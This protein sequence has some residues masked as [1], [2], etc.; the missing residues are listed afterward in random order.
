MSAR[1]SDPED[2]S[3]L[4]EATKVVWEKADPLGP[5]SHLPEEEKLHAIVHYINT[6]RISPNP[7]DVETAADMLPQLAQFPSIHSRRCALR[8]AEHFPQA[9]LAKQYWK[10]FS[11]V[12]FDQTASELYLLL[13]SRSNNNA[14][15][16]LETIFG[17]K[18][19]T[20]SS[21]PA[22]CYL[23]ALLCCLRP[24]NIDVARILYQQFSNNSENS[25]DVGLHTLLLDVFRRALRYPHIIKTHQPDKI[26]SIVREIKFPTLLSQRQVDSKKRLILLDRI[27]EIME[28]RFNQRLDDETKERVRGDMKFALRWREIIRNENSSDEKPPEVELPEDVPSTSPNSG[29][30]SSTQS[31]IRE[32][33]R[34]AI[35]ATALRRRAAVDDKFI[36][37]L[38]SQRRLRQPAT[39]LRA[40]NRS[41]STFSRRLHP[42]TPNETRR[43]FNYTKRKKRFRR[44]VINPEIVAEPKNTEYVSSSREDISLDT[45]WRSPLYT[46]KERVVTRTGFMDEK[47]AENI[48]KFKRLDEE[49]EKFGSE[50]GSWNSA[51]PQDPHTT[52]DVEESSFTDNSVQDEF[53]TSIFW[54]TDAEE[55]DT[56]STASLPTRKSKKELPPTTSATWDPFTAMYFL[57]QARSEMEDKENRMPTPIPPKA[58]LIRLPETADKNNTKESGENVVN[59]RVA[60]PPVIKRK[61]IVIRLLDE[62]AQPSNVES[63]PD[64]SIVKRPTSPASPTPSSS[65][66]SVDETT[67][68]APRSSENGTLRSISTQSSSQRP[69]V[70]PTAIE[71]RISSMRERFRSAD[72]ETENG[73]SEGRPCD[74][75]SM[76]AEDRI[77]L[78]RGRMDRVISSKSDNF[79]GNS[80]A[81]KGEASKNVQQRQARNVAIPIGV[82][83]S[84]PKSLQKANEWTRFKQKG[85]E[86]IHKAETRS[87]VGA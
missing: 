57:S 42:N 63:E 48:K 40:N 54:N 28:W 84:G 15:E 43:P 78:M 76:S 8:L 29:T 62:P 79:A 46:G 85:W 23:H 41:F 60:E 38:A 51:S 26:Y 35:N 58:V 12:P 32:T 6:L 4:I 67:P 25:R 36:S 44:P 64:T 56:D 24:P 80:V 10:H 55:V 17:I 59:Y 71:E 11:D 47:N 31:E 2:L 50:N 1:E 75:L 49:D 83:E 53:T 18:E 66:E 68:N 74:V 39:P 14:E 69:R 27:T 70:I 16:A 7:E 45:S 9:I 72:S 37:R 82:S 19:N 3:E 22:K 81:R 77:L 33:P 34:P 86:L 65:I 87:Y 20:R 52:R 5:D 61:P 21:I 13:L 73:S 30:T